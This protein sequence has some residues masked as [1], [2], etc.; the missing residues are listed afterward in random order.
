MGS[1]QSPTAAQRDT[2]MKAAELQ[3]LGPPERVTIADRRA[4]VTF[5]LPRQGVSLVRLT[6]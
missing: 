4:V 5:A 1:P 2:L 6:W 3:T